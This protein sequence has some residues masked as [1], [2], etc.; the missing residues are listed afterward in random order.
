MAEPT[1]ALPFG[2][3]HTGTSGLDLSFLWKQRL[4]FFIGATAKDIKTLEGYF[5]VVLSFLNAW[6]PTSLVGHRKLF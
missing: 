5:F 3:L 6:L 2:K 4:S 1:G